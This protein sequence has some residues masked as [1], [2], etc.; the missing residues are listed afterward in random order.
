MIRRIVWTRYWTAAYQ[1]GKSFMEPV[2]LRVPLPCALQEL[3]NEPMSKVVS[4]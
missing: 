4:V 2:L 3:W 1:S